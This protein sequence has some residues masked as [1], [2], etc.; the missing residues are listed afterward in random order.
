[1]NKT[2]K[3]LLWVIALL[4]M[5]NLTIIGTILIRNRENSSDNIAI[6]LDETRQTPL[7]GR[8]FRQTL[9]FNDAQM[10]VFRDAHRTF[11]YRANDLIYGMDSLKN[12]IFAELN[13]QTPDTLRLNNLSEQVG[14]HHA[15]L[16]KITNVFYLQLKTVCDSTQCEQLQQAFLPLF[17]DGNITP[18]RGYQWNDSIG[19]GQEKRHHYNY[20]GE[21]E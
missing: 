7:T 10:N 15:E 2:V 20:R 8:Y 12:E 17:R 11:Q 1:M 13:K 16:K 6:I 4:V 19:S 14:N 9:G 5:L 18:G 3:I 21:R